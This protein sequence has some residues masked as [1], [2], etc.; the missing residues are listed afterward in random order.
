VVELTDEATLGRMWDSADALP[1]LAELQEPRL[2][3]ART[4]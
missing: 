3:L 2:W 1:G 4:V